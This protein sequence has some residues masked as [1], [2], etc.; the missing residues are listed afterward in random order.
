[1]PRPTVII[2]GFER[3][4]TPTAMAMAPT[5]K[6]CWVPVTASAPTSNSTKGDEERKTP[7]TFPM[8]F[9]PRL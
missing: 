2:T 9:A 4:M 5:K 6:S 7:I 1:M 8:L 3:V